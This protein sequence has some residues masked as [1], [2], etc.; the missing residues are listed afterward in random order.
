MQQTIFN[1]QCKF[2]L[3]I[4]NIIDIPNFD[5]PEI[6]FWGRSNV[7]KSNLINS[8]LGTKKL[9][10]VSNTPG[11]TKEINFF[12]LANC[13]ILADLPGYGFAKTDKS[14]KKDWDKLFIGYLRNRFCL[15]RIFLLIDSRFGLKPID[16]E[17][18]DLLDYIGKSYVVVLTKSDKISS[19][20]LNSIYTKTFEDT[21]KHPAAYP[22]IFKT[23]ANKKLGILD[24]QN[25]I[26][27]TVL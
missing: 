17:V 3:G 20:E 21:K 22:E 10:K 13:I 12:S 7:G 23:S 19:T 18:M 4:R 8:L 5:L 16:Q 1:K 2:I 15:K 27:N 25:H 26:L 11:K 9:V 6:A 24:I 14:T